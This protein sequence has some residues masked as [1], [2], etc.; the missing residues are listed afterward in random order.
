MLSGGP[1]VHQKNVSP[2]EP[3]SPS[4]LA[5]RFARLVQLVADGAEP[6]SR[7]RDAVR[8]LAKA[9]GGA[10]VGIAPDG[11]GTIL[12]DGAAVA[13]ESPEDTVALALLAGR[14]N[15][16]GVEELT[17]TPKAAQA[18]LN[19]L[20]RLL[21]ALPAG[22]DPAAFFAARA[23]TVDVRGIPRRLRAR[24][25]AAA[26]EPAPEP[27]PAAAAPVAPQPELAEPVVVAPGSAADTRSERLAEAIDLPA[28]D[29][30]EL[31]ALFKRLQDATDASTLGPLLEALGSRADLA[32]RTGQQIILADAVG[33]LIAIEHVQLEVDASEARRSAFSQALRRLATPLILR[34]FAVMRHRLASD[35]PLAQ[36]LQAILF[37][38]GTDGAEAMIDEYVS[39][40]TEEERRTCLDALRGLGRTHDALFALVR[41]TRDLVVR[42]AAG[43]LGA[44]REDTGEQILVE[45][46]R[47]PDARSRRA[48]V[49]ALAQF[50][51]PT[52]TDALGLALQDESPMVRMRAVAALTERGPSAAALLAPLLENE[53][54]REV[55]Y[56]TVA[57]LGVI[58]TPEAVQLLVRVAQG[59]TEHSRKRSAGHRI[60][61]CE[62]LVAVRSPQAMACVQ[63]L[64]EDR[65]RE[66]RDAA[67]RLVAQASRRSTTMR[68]AVAP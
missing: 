45:L 15:A 56:S 24:V 31:A 61:A 3:T 68:A 58:G 13:G 66:V 67:V 38:F 9:V 20:A 39:V 48:A 8:A 57:G 60:R 51:T 50:S 33:G 43:I 29:D 37:R 7:Q 18:D 16:Y 17:L 49:A 2:K 53:G 64:R 28:T 21:A 40:A 26:S 27:E 14:M 30:A 59:D 42:Q 34:Q 1:V 11:T 10:S 25:V 44:L 52:S 19:D 65:D 62:A 22:D 35:A 55:L 46:L 36:R 41:D 23:S 54:D 12:A 32:F 5:L 63:S 6:A 4:S 47:H